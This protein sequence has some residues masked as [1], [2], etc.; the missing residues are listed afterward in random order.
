MR[1][2]FRDV[3]IINGDWG[4]GRAG[5]FDH[6]SWHILCHLAGASGV[7]ESSSGRAWCGITH[8]PASDTYQAT[9][10]AIDM[11]MDFLLSA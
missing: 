6:G 2:L 1:A 5:D 7:P 11:D 4:P 10:S 3:G 8:V 9:D